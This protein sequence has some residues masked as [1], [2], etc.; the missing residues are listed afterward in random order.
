MKRS[1]VALALLPALACS[2]PPD[3]KQPT[4]GPEPGST[5]N[6]DEENTGKENPP[7]EA[8]GEIKSLA[9]GNN[10]FAF[11]LYQRLK[12]QEGNLFFSPSSISTALAMTYAGMKGETATETARTLHFTLPP[13]RL[14]PAFATLLSQYNAEGK[15]YQLSVANRL[16]GQ[17]DYSFLD[18]YLA[19]TREQYGA[20]L[21][22]VDFVNAAEE[23]RQTINKWVEEKTQGKIEDLI[24]KGMLDSTSRLVLTNAIYF[25]GDWAKKFNPE[26]TSPQPFFVAKDQSKEVPMMYQS[27]KF[28]NARAD[29]VQILEM[30]YA[31]GDLSMVILLPEQQDGL[32]DLEAKLSEENVTRW[33][34]ALRETEVAVS[35]PKFTMSSEF[36]LGKTLSEMG[37]ARAFTR[38]ADLSGMSTQEDLFISEV[39]HKGFVEVN[40]EGTEAAA[41]T[42][43]GIRATAMPPMFR[44]DHPFVFLIRDTK[45]G[46]ILFLGRVV[47]PAPAG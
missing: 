11:D 22:Q 17:K 31:G 30:P 38:E 39:V 7:Q 20:E 6:A 2:E 1:I 29:G 32:A 46:N 40:E 44:A 36:T 25:K 43:V 41:A 18:S 28:P 37:M 42:G 21:E 24:P 12:G 14:H 9:Q 35:L 5:A 16:W 47:D 4:S 26:S 3:V 27:D 33:L 8:S 23:A 45:T 15:S 34:S 10:L 19:L 13:E